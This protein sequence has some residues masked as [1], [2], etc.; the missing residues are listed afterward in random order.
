MKRLVG[1]L[2]AA[3]L[4]LTG[5]GKDAG[6]R[7]PLDPACREVVAGEVA[8]GAL[9]ELE[10]DGLSPEQSGLEH[11]VAEINAAGGLGGQPLGLVL[12]DDRAD[13]DESLRLL[14]HLSGDGRIGAVIGPTRS[15]VALGMDGT[16]GIAHAAGEQ[17]LVLVSPSATSPGLAQVADDGYVFRTTVSDAVQGA[18]LARVARER[19]LARVFVLETEGDPYTRG[20]REEFVRAFEADGGSAAFRAFSASTPAEELLAAVDADGAEAV[21]VSAFPE[22]S[23]GLLAA[24]PAYAWSGARPATWLVPEGMKVDEALPALRGLAATGVEVVGTN[25]SLP[26]SAAYRAFAASHRDHHGE[27]PP[28]FA[29]NAYDAVYLVAAAMLLAEDPTSGP[30]I[31]DALPHTQRGQ[32]SAALGPTQ[33]PQIQQACLAEGGFDLVGASGDLELDANGDVLSNIDEWTIENESFT[34]KR[35]WTPAGD[36]C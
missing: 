23:A 32:G 4:G 35:C 11:A 7:A 3:V 22:E 31:R 15:V 17:Q 10:P 6:G 36:G 14:D 12:C 8:L 29:A 21:L 16:Y 27:E 24:A 30:A 34:F 26:R 19:G 20:I 9:M 2:A 33:W 28:V 18:V 13:P 25:P 5:C 1:G